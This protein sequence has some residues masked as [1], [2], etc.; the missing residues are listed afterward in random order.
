MTCSHCVAAGRDVFAGPL[1]RRKLRR[2]RKKGPSRTTGLLLSG[3][4]Q[5]GVED[6]TILDVGGGVGVI[7]QELLAT[8]AA[9]VVEVEA[10]PEFA[11]VARQEAAGRGTAD[12]M[13]VLEGD[14]VDLAP[15]LAPADT[16]TLDRVICCYPHMRLLLGASATRARRLVGLL[17][18]REHVVVRLAVRL[19]NLGQRVRRSPFRVYV[20]ASSDVEDEL[21]RHGF[22]RAWES[23]TWLWRVRVYERR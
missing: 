19:L 16:V 7:G 20:H 21:E 6:A 11:A 8:G 22:H 1:V 17:F 3:L 14:F 23:R 13:E 10:S 5:Q 2:Y 15:D 4:R 12:R 9:S 18:P